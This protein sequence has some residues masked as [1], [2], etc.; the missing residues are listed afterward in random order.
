M[1]SNLLLVFIV[2]CLSQICAGFYL[3]GMAPVSFCESER[4]LSSG[5]KCKS[6]ILLFVNSLDSVENIIPYEYDKFDFCHDEKDAS[7]SENLGQVVFGE[8]IRPSP[9]QFDFNK[10]KTCVKVCSKQYKETK[11][12]KASLS[13][14]AKGVEENYQHHWIVD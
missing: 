8:R 4:E 10:N 9:Y 5:E 14:L 6:K 7:P 12:D 13:F 11:E 1:L 3:P 2:S